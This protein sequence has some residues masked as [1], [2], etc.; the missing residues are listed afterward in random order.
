MYLNSENSFHNVTPAINERLWY[1][2]RIKIL[3]IGLPDYLLTGL[4]SVK[5]VSVKCLD[6]VLLLRV[7][8]ATLVLSEI[9]SAIMVMDVA[10][11]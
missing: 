9:N 8:L 11:N 1:Y 7:N 4:I 3:T 5:N 2:C 10:G 6:V